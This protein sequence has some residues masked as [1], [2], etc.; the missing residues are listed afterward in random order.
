MKSLFKIWKGVFYLFGVA[1]I[2]HST[3]SYNFRTGINIDNIHYI[4]ACIL[5]VVMIT[6]MFCCDALADIRDSK[7]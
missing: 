5:G 6:G 2:G 3:I 4:T 7:Q 1:L